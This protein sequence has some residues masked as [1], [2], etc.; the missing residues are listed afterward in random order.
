ML[1]A[2]DLLLQMRGGG[3]IHGPVVRSHEHSLN[4][5]VRRL[6]MKCALSVSKAIAPPAVHRLP[7]TVVS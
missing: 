1:K 6:G 4:R 3:V 5:K 2:L 7:L